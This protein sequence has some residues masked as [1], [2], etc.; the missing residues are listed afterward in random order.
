MDKLNFDREQ[1]LSHANS[2]QEAVDTVVNNSAK[3]PS[4]V[5]VPNE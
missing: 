5:I 4:Q 1:L 3:Q 2:A